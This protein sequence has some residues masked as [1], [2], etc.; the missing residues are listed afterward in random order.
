[1][2]TGA[3]DDDPSGIATYSIAGA[4][5]GNQFLWTAFITW[6]LM[7]SVQ[8]MSARIGMVSG[9]GLAGAFQQKFPRWLSGLFAFALFAAN[10]VNIASD[11]A[12]M[13]DAAAMLGGGNASIW[14]TAFGFGLCAAAI[15]LK[16]RQIARVLQWLALALFAY[17]IAAFLVHVDWRD[18]AKSTFV[19]TLP[20][21]REAWA[22]LVAI[23]GTTISPY[24]FYWQ[25]GQ[26]IE[27][28]KAKGKKSIAQRRGASVRDIGAR[29]MDVATGTFFSNL[30]MFFIFITTA[31]TL[32]ASGHAHVDT[33]RQAAEALRPLAGNV[34]YWLFSAGLLG[35]GMLAV[36]VLAGSAAYAF[37][38][39]FGWRYGL[40]KEFRRAPWFYAVFILATVLAILIVAFGI[41]PMRAL[42]WSAVIN[43]LLAP[44]VL[45]CMY[46]V[47]VDRR[48]MNGQVTPWLPRMVVALTIVV[49]VGAAI[50]MFAF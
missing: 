16:Y 36:P 49:M 2:T 42:F 11:L 43:G 34:C 44:V 9:R 41:D 25:A 26:E 50:G 24:L 21:G 5:F 32:H 28:Q 14:A 7:A 4:Q 33:T 8:M 12:G 35:T 45:A 3:A 20:K 47:A 10:T 29:Q 19:P 22:T 48:I 6:P 39:T 23:L 1:V 17:V 15:R 38:E 18:V 46:A 40:D 30:I 27:E 31:A 37:A 13:G